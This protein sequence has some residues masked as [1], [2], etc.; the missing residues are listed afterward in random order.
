[1][2]ESK[3]T[4]GITPRGNKLLVK[5]EEIL[6]KTASGLILPMQ[7]VERE[8][9]AQMYGSVVAIGPHCWPD[10]PERRC[11]I[12]DRIIFAKYAGEMFKGNDGITYRLINA[13]DVVATHD[14]VK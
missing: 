11:E 7:A 2:S 10:E 14:P 5:P 8:A 13:R 3:N 12:G 6:E 9:M 4:S 1:M